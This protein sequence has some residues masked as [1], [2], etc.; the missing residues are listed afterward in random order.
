MYLTTSIVLRI[1]IHHYCFYETY[2]QKTIAGTS[3]C[4]LVPFELH[5]SDEYHIDPSR[6]VIPLNNCRRTTLT[7]T[8]PAAV[9]ELSLCPSSEILTAKC[10]GQVRNRQGGREPRGCS[11]SRSTKRLSRFTGAHQDH[12]HRRPAM[13]GLLTA[14]AS[15]QVALLGTLP[16][17]QLLL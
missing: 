12:S 11:T 3:Q 2:K 5:T 13:R 6:R 9:Q 16:N 1:C 17:V 10:V 14:E 7:A 8:R 4:Y 15:L